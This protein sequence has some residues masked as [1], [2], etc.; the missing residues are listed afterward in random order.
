MNTQRN[1][2]VCGKP[3]AANPP[4]GLC[5]ECLMK[6]A[7]G[8]GADP[9]P[10]T[11]SN[12]KQ[13]AFNPPA[14][15]ELAAQ[16]PQLEILEFIGKGGMG[17]V[18]KARQKQLNRIVALK[19]LPPQAAT[20]AGFAERFAREARALAKLNHPHIVTLYEFGQ[21]D[22]L[23]YFLMEYVDGI[24]LRQLLGSGRISPREALAIVP[25]ICE[26]LQFAHDEGIVHRDIKPENIL[27]DKKGQVKIADFGVAKIV[28]EGLSE[29]AE[30][31]PATSGELTAVGSTLGTPQYMAPEQ[32]KNS[33][34]VDHRADIYSLGVVFYQMLTGEL[35]AGKIE[36]PS[37]K[38][39]IDVRLDEVVLRALEKKPEL[40][41]QQASALKTE[42]ET[43]ASSPGSAYEAPPAAVP[44][45]RRRDRWP[46][47]TDNV[48]LMAFVPGMV[49]SILVAVLAPFFGIRSL[50]ALI[51]A[52]A[53]L[54]F[55][56]TFGFVGSR[57]RNLK[58]ELPKTDAEVAEALIFE[59]PWQAPGLALLYSD[60]L[61][62]RAI[63]TIDQLVIPLVEIAS[64][65][66]VQ[67]F[68][69]RKLWWKRGF[70]LDLKN[71]RRVGVAVPEPYGRRWRA[72]LSGGALPEIP[73]NEAGAADT[74]RLHSQSQSAA[75]QYNP[76]E[77]VI[78]GFA[79]FFCVVIFMMCFSLAL[80]F[81]R[82]AAAPVFAM[83]MC[84]L[85]VCVC[86]L[87][88]AGLWPFPSWLFP[89][90]S[91]SSRN[92]SRPNDSA[93]ARNTKR[94]LLRIAVIG[95]SVVGLLAIIGITIHGIRQQTTPASTFS[96][97]TTRVR[98][99][100]PVLDITAAA[101]HKGDIGVYINALGVVESS[102]VVSFAISEDYVEQVVR[103]FDAGQKLAVEAF[104]RHN[105]KFG[106]GTLIGVNN[107]IDANTGT[108]TCKADL[109]PEN[110]QLMIPG[111]FLNIRLLLEVRRDA[112]L[113]PAATIQRDAQSAYVW[114]I[115][116]DHKVT[117]RTVKVGT[118]DTDITE[119][120]EGLAPGEMVAADEFNTLQD[121]T[122]VSFQTPH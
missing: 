46:W 53:G 102:N 11:Q 18:Y 104:N 38:V 108:L 36:P 100:L 87:R 76:L 80:A 47:D 67:V 7:L 75:P 58:A 70:V 77:K 68:N 105:E 44:I 63:A 4:E 82:Q 86:G 118:T 22:G 29:A 40:R 89:E 85:G 16:F 12:P 5:P 96:N 55:A 101:A 107:Q 30:D 23:F 56:A 21:A 94:R 6:A 95:A 31:S 50:L 33:A 20:G 93:S 1:C 115:N 10:D 110:G 111:L 17:A 88:L 117:R 112:T 25:Q 71:G 109:V 2:P 32:I 9:G 91:F 41:Y 98:R 83:G 52:G 49:S 61:E 113:I 45:L 27:L 74:P 90:P 92:L 28:A 99:E 72:K 51:P 103:K 19:I 69:G 54:L 120:Q 62:L 39:A 60:R 59:R 106:R 35:P 3:L 13:S 14:V 81:R 64:I 121:G 37:K 84:V 66:E 79:M 15:S 42:V 34:E 8:T 65:N 48:V 26:A 119:I 57:V 24:T 116:S 73:A 78:I 114:V 43:I 122:P 97:G